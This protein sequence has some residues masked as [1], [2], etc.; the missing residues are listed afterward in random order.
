MG[1]PGVVTREAAGREQ[2]RRRVRGIERAAGDRGACRAADRR[3]RRAV[4]ARDAYA[5]AAVQPTTGAPPACSASVRARRRAAG[6]ASQGR[7]ADDQPLRAA[8]S[9][10]QA[11]LA[12]AVDLLGPR[13][14]RRA[15]RSIATAGAIASLCASRSSR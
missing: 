4:E 14:D 7:A 15:A 3:R 1:W 5:A 2:L 8:P 13:D 12:H 6:S 9:R 11:A 10:D